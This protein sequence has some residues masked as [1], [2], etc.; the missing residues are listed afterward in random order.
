MHLVKTKYIQ[1]NV[2][3]FIE[4]INTIIPKTTTYTSFYKSAYINTMLLYYLKLHLSLCI[5]VLILD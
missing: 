3:H 1:K 2:N 5:D 4:Y